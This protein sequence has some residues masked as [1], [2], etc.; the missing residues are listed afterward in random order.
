MDPKKLTRSNSCPAMKS[1]GNKTREVRYSTNDNINET[2]LEASKPGIRALLELSI[3]PVAFV[4]VSKVDIAPR[5]LSTNEAARCN[6]TA[7]APLQTAVRSKAIVPETV[8][9]DDGSAWFSQPFGKYR[10]YNLVKKEDRM[11]PGEVERL[12]NELHEEK[13][14]VELYRKAYEDMKFESSDT[15]RQVSFGP[16]AS[17]SSSLL[18]W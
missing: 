10:V 7:L 8:E 9:V 2:I 3:T 18:P 13:Q 16:H 4:D 12:R 17:H 6:K 11:D 15:A 14:K 5:Y 1:E